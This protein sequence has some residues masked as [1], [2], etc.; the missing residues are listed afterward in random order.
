LGRWT[1]SQVLAGA[2]LATTGAALYTWRRI[3]QAAAAPGEAS[4][5]AILVFGARATEHGPSPELAARL[6]HAA[7]LYA[8]GCA[9]KIVCSGGVSGTVSEPEVMAR[10]LREAGIPSEHVITDE[11]GRST[12]A[13]L[14]AERERIN[15]SGERLLAVSSPF[16]MHR[17]DLEARRHGL[18]VVPAP[19]PTTPIAS[20]PP[21]HV[22]WR[23]REVIAVWFYAIPGSRH[24]PI[25]TMVRAWRGRRQV[26]GTSR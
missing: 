2:A 3:D 26:T 1:V 19:P 4:A 6:A 25:A 5:D 15:G 16:H 24:L 13:T 18:D 20:C 22:R 21:K 12:R 14:A 17:I 23:L 11:R 8:R 7:N 10:V 9:R